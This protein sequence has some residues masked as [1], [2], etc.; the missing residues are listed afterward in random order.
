MVQGNVNKIHIFIIRIIF[1][2]CTTSLEK[3]KMKMSSILSSQ[4]ETSLET[5]V[6]DQT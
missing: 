1:R 6:F 2:F 5:E 3:F 4:I